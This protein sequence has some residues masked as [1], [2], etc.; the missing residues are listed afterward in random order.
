MTAR[1]VR[2]AGSLVEVT[3]LRAALYDLAVVGDRRMMGEVIRQRGDVATVQVYEDTTGLAVGEPVDS[4]GVA[5]TAQLGPGLLGAILDGVGR[6]LA[7]LAE[8]TGDFIAA[9][10]Q[11]DTLDASVRWEFTATRAAGEVV[12]PGDILGHVREPSGRAHAILVPPDAGGTIAAIAGGAFTVSDAVGAFADGR[13]IRL[14]H[15]WPVRVPRPVARRLP[16][17]Q[18]FITGQRVFDLFF[19]VAEGGA[20]VVPGGFGTG[21]TIIEQSLAK[22]ADADIVVYV[23]CGERGNEMTDVL[24]EFPALQ[25]PRTGRPV[26]E[27]AV[28]IVNTS[29]MPVAA[30]EASI[31]L[32]V[33]V[34]EYFRDQ[35]N[36]VALMIDSTSRWAEA[37]REMAAR[38][39]EMPGEEG[40]PTYLANRMGQFFERAGRADVLGG[41]PRQGAVT[42]IGAVSPPGGDFSEP[43]TQSAL[44]VTGAMWALDAALAHQR[45]YPAVDWEASFSLYAGLVAPWLARQ[46][47]SAWS[48]V[49]AEL[50]TLL[51]R[52]RE[53]RD[54]ASLVGPDALEDRDRLVI[55]LAVLVRETVLRQNAY[56]PHDARSSLEKTFAL[57][58]A[59]LRAYQAGALAVAGGQ[60]YATLD[61]APVRRALSA[62]RDAPDADVP[63]RTA[64]ARAAAQALA[65]P[66]VPAASSG[67]G[68]DAPTPVGVTP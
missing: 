45:H 24:T 55:D 7:R 66:T 53:L 64:D 56:H 60:S 36:R 35:G 48:G 43:V 29:N 5:L 31:Y 28:L 6:P 17:E 13:P 3:P 26:M 12:A 20:A 2:V 46:A 19:P 4:L 21:K 14:A 59:A 8:A 9:G 57:A 11:V 50:L 40:Y 22:Y 16:A 63:A 34:A 47:G 1:I 54:I 10:A 67:V 39:Q 37:L 41:P 61:L 49:R 68:A 58:D 51:Q 44:R 30:R 33:T 62:L 27:R 32:G 65:P 42:I 23:G 18:A 25:D 52:D 38:L 15:R